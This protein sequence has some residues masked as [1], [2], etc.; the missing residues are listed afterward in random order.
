MRLVSD[1][2]LVHAGIT[3]LNGVRPRKKMSV[4]CSQN[5]PLDA[6]KNIVSNGFPD[7]SF[8]SHYSDSMAMKLLRIV[9]LSR[10]VA[11]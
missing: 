6:L 7:T 4:I 8:A 2:S 9:F 10:Y 11:A 5:I 1:T 3:N